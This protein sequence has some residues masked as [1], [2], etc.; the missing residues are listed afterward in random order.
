MTTKTAATPTRS[1]ITGCLALLCCLLL[2][3]A[4]SSAGTITT[5]AGNPLV[6]GLATNLGQHPHAVVVA[7]GG[8][9]YV[10]DAEQA[11]VRRV[12]P[13][14]QEE[15]VIAGD[16]SGPTGAHAF[17]VGSP[18][19]ATAT[20]LQPQAL[21]LDSAGDLLIGDGNKS[22]PGGVG[23]LAAADCSSSCPFGLPDMTKG[24]IYAIAGGEQFGNFPGD[25]EPANAAAVEPTALTLDDSGDI[26]MAQ[27]G[28]SLSGCGGVVSLI[29]ATNC[30]SACPFGLS[31]MVEGHIYTVA[32]GGENTPNNG[33]PATAVALN[34][35]QSV[36]LDS[37]GDL[38][39]GTWAVSGAG[40]LGTVQL[41]AET[42][43]VAECP[44]SLAATT[45]GDIYTI[46]GGGASSPGDGGPAV[47]AKLDSAGVAFD[48]AGNL[49]IGDDFN[50]R[51]RLVA[52]ASCSSACPFGLASITRGDIYTIA[53]GGA[54]LGDGGPAT[55]A[56]VEPVALAFD[57]AGN[58]LLSDQ[59]GA[60]LR[61]LAAADCTSTC[62]FGL[63][64][65]TKNDIYTVVGNGTGYSGD[66]GPAT[67][68]QLDWPTGIAVTGSGD[69]VISDTLNDRVALVAGADCSASCPFGLSTTSKGDVYTIAGAGPGF[70]SEGVPATSTHV[71]SPG[72]ITV[73][74]TGDVLLDTITQVKL[75]AAANCFSNCPLGLSAMTKGDIYVVAG[76]LSGSVSGDDEPAKA[77]GLGDPTGITEDGA[78]DLLIANYGRVRLVANANCA[79]NCPFGLPS[80]AK[81]DI[82]TIAGGGSGQG[83]AEPATA[84][85]LSNALGLAVDSRGDV[86]VAA[87]A[88]FLIAAS[89]CASACPYSLPAMTKGYMYRVAG[90]VS[91]G[92]DFGDGVPATSE[93]LEGPTGLTVDSGDDLLIAES[94]R[95][96]VRFVANANC[97][98]AC[99]FG[100]PSITKG[101]IYTIAGTST[102]G[103][104]GDGGPARAAQ[105]DFPFALTMDTAGNLLIADTEN[106]RIRLVT[107]NT[108][109]K[110]EEPPHEEEPHDE[111][112]APR[113]GG[114]DTNNGTPLINDGGVSAV[115]GI[116]STQLKALLARQLTPSG[117]AATIAALLKHGGLSLSFT[118]P[119]AGSL[120]IQWFQVPS[121]AKLAK[122]TK[123]KPVLMASGKLTFSTAGTG[124]L[125]IRLTAQGR[126]LLKQVRRVRLMAK[127]TFTPRGGVAVSSIGGVRLRR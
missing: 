83:A 37:S 35:P 22:R 120:A 111:A 18:T 84:A 98:A 44:F 121:G 81:G 32:G 12:D 55:A 34:T 56:Q 73:D 92:P 74:S 33:E 20:P 96:A 76:T 106:D 115:P 30:A 69:T 23:L 26:V 75:V 119:E 62:P 1:L 11:L 38:V 78:G 48:N 103:F 113:M 124:K 102:A 24:H 15:T 9:V 79:S 61:L 39:V 59:S 89:N 86:L 45:K 14:T 54:A 118:A 57:G 43:C 52:R 31:S 90:I 126:K 40:G 2:I 46:A 66:G 28:C 47:N 105:L 51:V 7:P 42:N 88:V 17:V 70:A 85:S 67:A 19:L 5:V 109:S 112:P 72:G 100:L 114:G 123:T 116:S 91:G 82:Y 68:A 101:D 99:P 29:A 80:T 27:S 125:T 64:S 25:G 63:A 41:I 49:L 4:S 71:F 87:R 127:G 58:V 77:A 94:G 107:A 95:S 110:A 10:A 3:P 65:L 108:E 104:S 21:A 8:T 93:F 13:T 36:A 53:G 122:A 6:S 117:K 50:G 60:R 16:G 97:S